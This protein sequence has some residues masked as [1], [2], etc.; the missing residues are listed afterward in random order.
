MDKETKICPHCGKEILAIA[1]KCK[2]CKQWIEQPATDEAPATDSV[3][4][5][6]EEV[7][8]QPNNE[9]PEE[10]VEEKPVS[11]YHPPVDTQEEE[12]VEYESDNSFSKYTGWIIGGIAVIALIILLCSK[13]CSSSSATSDDTDEEVAEVAVEADEDGKHNEDYIRQRVQE[14]YDSNR[15]DKEKAYTTEE[16]YSLYKQVQEINNNLRGEV[17]F[18]FYHWGNSQ[19]PE[20]PVAKVGEVYTYDIDIANVDV[21]ITDHGDEW[22]T[23]LNLKFENGDWYVDDFRGREKDAMKKF[24]SESKSASDK[25]NAT[26]NLVGTWKAE[27]GNS[28]TIS[29]YIDGSSTKFKITNLF[30]YRNYESSYGVGEMKSKNEAIATFYEDTYQYQIKIKILNSNK[31]EVS[32]PSYYDQSVIETDIMLRQ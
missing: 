28:I 4:A 12:P 2:Y 15:S 30:L 20:H 5:T 19:D 26:I 29:N 7:A 3:P 6:T 22:S 27:Y 9:T 17:G 1:K 25:S 24:I 10:V 11:T 8:P 16:Y 31:I 18:E 21:V 32:Y 23:F 14:M 13:S